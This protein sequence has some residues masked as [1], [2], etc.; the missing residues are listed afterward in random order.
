MN[1]VIYNDHINSPNFGCKLVGNSIRKLVKEKFPNANII[2]KKDETFKPIQNIN[3]NKPDI[4]I[5][6][7]EGSFGHHYKEVKGWKLLEDIIGH[8]KAPTFLVNVTIQ[9][10]DGD[11]SDKQINLLKKCTRIFTRE[12]LSEDFLYTQGIK[13]VQTFPDAGCYYFKDE[14]PVDKDIDIV[15]GGGSLF[16]MI[17]LESVESY[18]QAFNKLADDGYSVELVDFPGYIRK[19][20]KSDVK[21]LKPY[22]SPKIK[23][24]EGGTFEDYY[25]IVKRAKV[26]VTGR[27]HGAVMSFMGRTPFI[28]YQANMWKTEGDQLLYGPF[29]SFDFK[30]TTTDELEL[31]VLNG[32]TKY[33]EWRNLLDKRYEELEPS[34]GAQIFTI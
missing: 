12:K 25:N 11:L 15:F 4:I 17:K 8:Y 14:P 2:Y 19:V 28:T 1:V 34:F 3:Q 5:I 9:G 6:N 10:P 26:H 23:I 22:C 29:D 33:R 31:L 30:E 27:H 16:K 13:D 24:N 7:G 18:V 20:P 21:I 32:L